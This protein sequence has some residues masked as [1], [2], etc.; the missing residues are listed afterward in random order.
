MPQTLR[1][2]KAVDEAINSG[3]VP[4]PNKRTTGRIMLPL[5]GKKYVTLVGNDGRATKIGQYYY[6][7]VGQSPPKSGFDSKQKTIKKGGSEYIKMYG[8]DKPRLVRAWNPGQGD[9]R[10]TQL[11]R[12]YFADGHQEVLASIPVLIKGHNKR[13]QLEY[14]RKGNL[15]H[16]TLGIELKLPITLSRSDMERRIKETVLKALPDGPIFQDSD[17]SYRVDSGGR[18]TYSTLTTQP[19]EGGK[20]VIDATL[21]RPLQASAPLR[22]DFFYDSE[23]MMPEAFEDSNVNCVV[24]QLSIQTEIP[25]AEIEGDFD[26]IFEQLPSANKESYDDRHWRELGV[27]AK[28]LLTWAEKRQVRASILWGARHIQSFV[29]TCRPHRIKS[30]CCTIWGSHLYFYS[31]P[32]SKKGAAQMPLSKCPVYQMSKMRMQRG[33]DENKVQDFE[34]LPEHLPDAGSFAV[35]QSDMDAVMAK[36]LENRMVPSVR[37]TDFTTIAAMKFGKL[38]V[39][40]LPDEWEQLQEFCAVL[41]MFSPICISYRGQG[42]ANLTLT[43]VI[44]LLRP[45]RT[46]VKEDKVGFCAI[47]GSEGR[48]ERDHIVPL[49]CGGISTQQICAHCH[50]EKTR[51]EALYLSDQRGEHRNPLLSHFEPNVWRDFVQNHRPV[52]YVTKVNDPVLQ[53]GNKCVHTDVKRCRQTALTHSEWTF[54]IFQATDTITRAVPGEMGDFMFVEKFGSDIWDMPYRGPSWYHRCA[55]EF[56]MKHGIIGWNHCKYALSASNHLPKTAF[57]LPL[58]YLKM[59]WDGTNVP[60]NYPLSSKQA[61]NAMVGLFGRRE[62][63]VYNTVYTTHSGDAVR[64]QGR[65]AE[66]VMQ[67]G[68]LEYTSRTDLLQSWTML[69]LYYYC[70]DWEATR[71]AAICTIIKSVAPTKGCLHIKTDGIVWECRQRHKIRQILATTS[72]ADLSVTGSCKD[73]TAAL[74]ACVGNAESPPVNGYSPFCDEILPNIQFSWNTFKETPHNDAEAYCKALVDGGQSLCILG[75]AGVGKSTLALN[76]MA[77]LRGKGERV[78]SLAKTHVCA[79][80]IL[81]KTLQSFIHRHVLNG[82]FGNGWIILDEIGCVELNLYNS[83][84]ACLVGGA[85][86]ILLG[87]FCQL[88]ACGDSNLRPVHSFENSR[89]FHTLAGGNLIAL[90]QYRRG[91]NRTLFNWYTSLNPSGARSHLDIQEQVAQARKAFPCRRGH[92]RWN[93]TIS[94]KKRI[95]LNRMINQD[96]CREPQ[97]TVIPGEEDED[98]EDLNRQQRMQLGPGVPIIGHINDVRTGIIHGAFYEV[99]AASA[100]GVVLRDIE[101]DAQLTLPVVKLNQVR[102]CYAC[103]YPSIQGR[104]LRTGQVRLHCTDHQFFTWRHLGVGLS[105]AISLEQ[106]EVA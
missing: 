39:K 103:T 12:A 6:K 69:P 28:M 41:T 30:V 46:Y 18:W 25:I 40:A 44:Q 81:G 66:R 19:G 2:E 73:T 43:A 31:S 11:G 99:V 78:Q 20:L 9:F 91:T 16:T 82:T 106:V 33:S 97:V 77:H 89:L 27:S 86:Y 54:P 59:A 22:Y 75:S 48:L 21:D 102:L 13:T 53:G 3:N 72:Y 24:K 64:M 94:H 104:T 23:G 80:N 42:L 57:Q 67:G 52:A 105:R 8:S 84:N 65:V 50:A 88:T 63:Y 56:M 74:T 29:P 95:A 34:M 45:Q 68:L 90:T 76:L 35:R 55:V 100:D 98:C 4:K 62:N 37:K 1:Q 87:D 61:V 93:L 85:K 47:C 32:A 26:D 49:S 83:L 58:A 60:N 79:S 51:N 17:E 96:L 14:E 92:A 101:T 10:Y 7:K 38:Q 36:F 15:W 71:V 70:L 5:Q